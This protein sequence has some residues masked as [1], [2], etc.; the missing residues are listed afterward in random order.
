MY[1]G[2]GEMMYGTASRLFNNG[3]VNVRTYCLCDLLDVNM[4]FD[5]DLNICLLFIYFNV[6]ILCSVF[7]LLCAI[8]GWGYGILK[9]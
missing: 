8:S 7:N 2:I 9:L 5:K 1:V 6:K 4:L 3:S